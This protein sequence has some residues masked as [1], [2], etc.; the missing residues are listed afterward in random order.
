M[1]GKRCL[2]FLGN[3]QIVDHTNHLFAEI[4]FDPFHKGA[5]KK[6]FSWKKNKQRVDYFR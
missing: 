6:F 5:F 3:I 2:S 4:R 1:F